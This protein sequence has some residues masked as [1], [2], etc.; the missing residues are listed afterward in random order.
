[1]KIKLWKG[2]KMAVSNVGVDYRATPL[3]EML[4]PEL[5]YNQ[6]VKTS[7]LIKDRVN[8]IIYPRTGQQTFSITPSNQ[9]V[10]EFQISNTAFTDHTTPCLLMDVQLIFDNSGANIWNQIAVDA[11]LS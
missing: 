3:A 2:N 7:T 6:S 8:N 1:M 5:S 10:I 4:T 11:N 9:P